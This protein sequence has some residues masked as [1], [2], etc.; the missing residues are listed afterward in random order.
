MLWRMLTLQLSQVPADK[1]VGA[2]GPNDEKAKPKLKYDAL[3]TTGS[4]P[5]RTLFLHTEAAKRYVNMLH[6]NGIAISDMYRSAESSLAAVASGRGAQPPAFSLH[7]YGIAIDLRIDD[8]MKRMR[9]KGLPI[10]TKLD[11]DNWMQA[12]GWYCHRTDH[13][14]ESEAWH[15][16]ALFLYTALGFADKPVAVDPKKFSTTSGFAEELIKKLYRDQL[17]PDD[18]ECQKMLAKIGMYKGEFDGKIGPISKAAI[19]AFQRAWGTG[20]DPDTFEVTYTLAQTGK[21]DDK[22]R[23]TLAFIA[24]DRNLVPVPT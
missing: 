4:M 14:L 2:Y 11:L 9:D 13:Q 19:Q 20:K 12:N 23:R 8:S 17:Y 16:N 6:P 10:K 1:V 15:Y 22:T 3:V 24:A 18:T 7:N 5:A 21:L